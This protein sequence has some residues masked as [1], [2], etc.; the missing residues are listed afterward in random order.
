MQICYN[1]NHFQTLIR[2][3]HMICLACQQGLKNEKTI[4]FENVSQSHSIIADY[5]K[6]IDMIIDATGE[7]MAV[8]LNDAILYRERIAHLI[9]SISVIQFSGYFACDEANDIHVCI[10]DPLNIS[11]SD[12]LLETDSTI[13][14]MV[15]TPVFNNSVGD[16]GD[17]VNAIES[18][19]SSDAIPGEASASW[20]AS[21]S[22][23]EEPR[24]SSDSVVNRQDELAGA[25]TITTQD[26]ESQLAQ[27]REQ[28]LKL[29]NAIHLL[30]I[31]NI[32]TS[33]CMLLYKL[34][35][36][37]M[38]Q[39]IKELEQQAA[40]LR[41]Q[42]H[43]ANPSIHNSHIGTPPAA[44]QPQIP[45]HNSPTRVIAPRFY[46]PSANIRPIPVQQQVA[47]PRAQ[48][49]FSNPG[50]HNS[51]IAAPPAAQ[52]H[53]ATMYRPTRG[54]DPRFYFPNANLSSVHGAP[55]PDPRLNR[56]F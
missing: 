53:Q 34:E 37:K 44:L 38:L 5:L 48:T 50:I 41:A 1:N 46:F 23:A 32:Q 21:A 43:F 47:P 45:M 54:I 3:I 52:Q 55:Q 36:Q 10:S 2:P 39:Y 20:G 51:H 22:A 24:A 4:L 31:H 35:N 6:Y 12:S 40:P 56:D 11:L 27:L 9:N 18:Y 7:N 29:I 49:H 13:E 42:T 28:N 26:S 30:L 15:N 8:I 25:E 33:Q 17:W 14:S 19:L 16:I